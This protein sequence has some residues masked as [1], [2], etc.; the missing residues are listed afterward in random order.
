MKIAVNTR[1]LLSGKL[2]GIGWFSFEILR[3]MVQ[4]HPEHEFFFLFDRK[5][6]PAFV[7]APNVVP[8][9]IFPPA[10]H[11]VLWYAW[12]EI[13]VPLVLRRIRPDVFIS[14]DGY[15]SLRTPTPTLLF[16]HDVSY[17]HE[18]MHI[19]FATRWYYRHFVPHFLKRTDRIITF[20]QSAQADLVHWFG[21]SPEKIAVSHGAARE[22]FQPISVGKSAQLR[23]ERTSGCPYFLYVGAIHPRKNVHRLLR[24]FDA[25]KS[26][27]GSDFKLLLAGRFAWKTGE[28]RTAYEK[29]RHR[30]DVVFLGHLA[31][32]E[33][34]DITAAAHALVYPSLYEG[35][36][37]P[38]IEAIQCGVPVVTSNVSSLPEV[39]GNAGLLVNPLSEEALAEALRQMAQDPVLH[40]AIA[41]Q[42]REQ[43]ARFSWERTAADVYAAMLATVDV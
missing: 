5:H 23:A 35:F 39:A 19:G 12:F 31:D 16:W 9:E 21:V 32:A 15:C 11:A 30:G 28:V 43:A 29:M 36:G 41:A 13:A 20:S 8:I 38:V 6:D 7:F 40:S 4:A 33:L 2:E 24:A 22:A 25:F 37:L 27:G 17:L 10:R 42:C 3:R 18:P 1:F 26:Q 34:V 14:T